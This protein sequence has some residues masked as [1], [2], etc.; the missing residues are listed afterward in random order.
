MLPMDLRLGKVCRLSFV[1]EQT[2]LNVHL[3]AYP[4]DHLPL[5]RSRLDSRCLPVKQASVP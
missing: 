3:D 4:W 1:A 5:P 2:V